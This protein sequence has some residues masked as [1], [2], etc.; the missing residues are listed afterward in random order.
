[1]KF[2]TV[3]MGGGLSG[4]TCG[5]ALA[6]AGQRVAIVAT[7]QSSLHFASGSFDLIGYDSEGKAVENPVEA[8][9]A[10]P[11]S[12]PYK[13]VGDVEK[14]AAQAQDL[15]AAAG[16]KTTGKAGKNHNRLT[17][18]GAV[19]PTWLTMEDYITIDGG[20]I[21]Y[22]QVALMNIIGY[23]DF[24]TKFIADGLRKLGAEVEVKPITLPELNEAR[25]SP[26]EMRA[27]N[28]AKVLAS[29]AIVKRLASEIN[30]KAG[31]A[32]A[33]LLPAVLGIKNSE[34]AQLLKEQV[35]KPIHF[36]ATIP[37]SVPG[38][39]MQ[40][41]LRKRFE[42]LGGTF[43]NGDKAVKGEISGTKLNSIETE[44]LVGTRL[45]AD[46][47]VLATGSFMGR[48]IVSDYEKVYEPVLGADVDFIADRTQ[49]TRDNVWEAQPY[50]E[51]G[52]KTDAQLHVMKQGKPLSNTYAAG[53][54]LS[55][56]NKVKLAS[57]EG[58]DMLTALTVA[59][60]IL[61]K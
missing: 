30:A 23:L 13:K 46:N 58:V 11:E 7:G 56:N 44:K 49:W 10:L 6:Q 3:I 31:N 5:I 28:I 18:L 60:N 59:N 15:L 51:F 27:T 19:K 55:G 54:V 32:E 40:A 39:R 37:P 20:K 61:N 26:T 16:V 53:Q 48:G 35:N 52:V 17:P 12:H 42:A 8:I 9:N 38:T 24:P 21:N 14:L 25:K 2:N 41:L 1:M 34:L 29:E 36:V 50:M 47:F 4:L 43:L 22:K 57:G 45:E 33:I